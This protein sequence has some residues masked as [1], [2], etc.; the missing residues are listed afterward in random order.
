MLSGV[1]ASVWVVVFCCAV[2]CTERRLWVR[3]EPPGAQVRVNGNDVGASPVAW[4]FDH[5]GT[6]LVE[7][8]LPGH[9]P[10]QRKVR[11]SPPWWQQPGADFF[12]DVVVPAKLRDDHEVSFTLAP[13]REP[14]PEQLDREV[15]RLAARA[16]KLRTEA[17]KP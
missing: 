4:R 15:R 17:E 7:A 5:Y 9:V 14:T 1:R 2:G 3:T 8:E 13:V 6:V 11:L 10:V 12:A 16:R